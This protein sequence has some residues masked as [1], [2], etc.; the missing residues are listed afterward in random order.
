MNQYWQY[1]PIIIAWLAFGIIHS[2]LAAAQTKEKLNLKAVNYRRLYT[3]ISILAVLFIFFLGSTIPPEY[4]F[5][6]DQR[7]KSIG[8][9]IATFGFLLA[10]LAFKPLSF[11]EFLGIRPEQNQKLIKSGI[12]ARMRHPLYTAF[13]LG[14]L[15]FVVF[16]PTYT[17][18]VHAVCLLIYVFV[19]IYF[20]EKRLIARFGKEYEK[21]KEE[22][23]MLF[24]SF[25]R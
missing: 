23:P 24:P 14:I 16:N 22:T 20:E 13:I 15:G 19:G 10:K 25:R 4:L 12:Y 8:L 5:P 9:I 18:L 3:V 11:S 7:S 2:V 17:H 6:K 21:Y 1:L